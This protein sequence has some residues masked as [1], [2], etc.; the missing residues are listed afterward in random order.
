MR[1]IVAAA[2][3]AVAA[4]LA[5]PTFAQD[6]K[7]ATGRQ[8]GYQYPISV[9]IAQVIQNAPGFG[10]V[11]LMPGGGTGNVIAVGSGKAEL[12]LTLSQD[13]RGGIEGLKP[14]PQKMPDVVQLFALN[15]SKV[16]IIVPEDSPIKAFKDLAG[17]K[18]NSGPVGFSITTLSR[19][20]YA[21]AGIDKKVD[22]GHL[23]VSDAV[24]Q[25]KDGHIDALFYAPSD[26]YGPYV[27]L[28]LSR[29]IRLVPLPGDIM[30]KLIAE[31]PSFYKSKFPIQPDLYKGLS[32][33]VDTI[34]YPTIII[35]NKAK[36]DDAKAYAITKA[37]AEHW[38]DVRSSE[39][40]LKLL[41]AQEMALQAGVPV[42]PGAL[43]YFR[44]RGW[45]K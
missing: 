12:G 19:K 10:Q 7:F 35:A 3:F 26:W 16:V 25:F 24:E 32:N 6:M 33:Q 34:G 23:Q 17:H 21:M 29:K 45:V 15:P 5:G 39:P 40:S 8:G 30:D 20:I 18:V 13:A 11:T 44:E 31:E 42:H 28:A 9:A 36:V 41:E 27:D 22:E 1:R 38:K 43:R 4:V 2:A 14:Y 37:V